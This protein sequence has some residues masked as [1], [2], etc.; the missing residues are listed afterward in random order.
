MSDYIDK[1]KYV[2]IAA[3]VFLL[4]LYIGEHYFPAINNIWGFLRWSVF[5]LVCLFPVYYHKRADLPCMIKIEDLD[6]IKND[7]EIIKK[8]INMERFVSIFSFLVVMMM[9]FMNLI[10]A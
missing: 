8:R 1:L 2:L 7:I 4:L 9:A 10:Y 6:G 3:G 5:S